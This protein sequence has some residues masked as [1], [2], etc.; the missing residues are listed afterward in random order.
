[1]ILAEVTVE[2]LLS[3][4][5]RGDDFRWVAIGLV[6]WSLGCVQKDHYGYYTRVFS[7]IDWIK[8]TME[9]NS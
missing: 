2:E 9:D 8:K 3:V 5:Q 6:S 1:M 7:F 4:R